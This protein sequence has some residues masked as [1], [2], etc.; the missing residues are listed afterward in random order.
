MANGRSPDQ[1]EHD[2]ELT[3]RM[4]LQGATQAAI[5]KHL[6]VTQ[7]TVSNDLKEIRIRWRESS[8]RDFDAIKEEQLAKINLAES[9]YWQ[10]WERSKETKITKRNEDG[11]TDKGALTKEVIIE[12]QKC[13]DPRYLDGVM[14]CIERRCALIGLDSELKYQDLSI[15]IGRVIQAGYVVQ[16]S[17]E[18]DQTA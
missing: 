3:A 1:K 10:E 18:P 15:A 13:G 9:Q 12:E 7:Q 8:I 2:L 5:A 4:Y 16:N 6:G 11:L 17:A 14:K